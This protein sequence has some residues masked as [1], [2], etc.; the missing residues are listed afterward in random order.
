MIA[1]A[2]ASEAAQ[3]VKRLETALAEAGDLTEP[4]RRARAGLSNRQVT[5]R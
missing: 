1:R 5:L 3:R 4:E 2:V